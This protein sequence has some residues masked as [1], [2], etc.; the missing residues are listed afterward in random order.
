MANQDY[1]TMN[2]G[3]E[4]ILEA[5]RHWVNVL[6]FFVSTSIVIAFGFFAIGYVG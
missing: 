2:P 6:P 4:V 3:E 5:H 1:L